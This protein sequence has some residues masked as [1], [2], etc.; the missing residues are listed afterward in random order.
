MEESHIYEMINEKFRFRLK[1]SDAMNFDCKPIEVSY[2]DLKSI[3][4]DNLE[5]FAEYERNHWDPDAVDWTKIQAAIVYLEPEDP[6]SLEGDLGGE[7]S[8]TWSEVKYFLLNAFSGL[9]VK[10]YEPQDGKYDGGLVICVDSP[11]LRD[12]QI[13][14]TM[15]FLEYLTKQ[16]QTYGEESIDFLESLKYYKNFSSDPDLLLEVNEGAFDDLNVLLASNYV[17]LEVIQDSVSELENKDIGWTPL[18]EEVRNLLSRTDALVSGFHT[19]FDEIK[20]KINLWRAE[21]KRRLQQLEDHYKEKLAIAEPKKVWDNAA[22]KHQNVARNW[23]IWAMIAASLMLVGG[24]FAIHKLYTTDLPEAPLLSKEFLAVSII[25]FCLYV[26]RLFVKL[27]ISNG[28]L[29]MAYKQKS[30]MTYFYLS[31]LDR[32]ESAIDDNERAL[33]LNSLFSSVD[34]GLI[35]PGESKESELLTAFALKKA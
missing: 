5:T 12:T 4:K 35:K 30:A 17:L 13:H 3:V 10:Q 26:I 1:F 29:A 21:E 16:A 19:E 23:S 34:T 7:M 9:I 25:T 6:S 20:S 24:T 27:A 14:R 28:H 18:K 33:I 8:D 15:A 31:L 32:K 11:C 2:S 22:A